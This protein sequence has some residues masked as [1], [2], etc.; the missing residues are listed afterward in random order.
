MALKYWARSASLGSK[1]PINSLTESKSIYTT[2]RNRLNGRTP[3]NIK[4][5]D[6]LEKHNLK[7]IEIQQQIFPAKFDLKSLNPKHELTTKIKKTE[8][9]MQECE[10]MAKTFF[11]NNYTR[12][13]QIY[14]DGSKDSAANTAGCAFTIPKLYK[15][16]TE[17]KI[18]PLL[19]VYEHQN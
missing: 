6:L 15:S 8:S 3:Y 12:H 2:C 18:T 13:L 14:T 10:K 16:H 7:E 1:L 19:T 5:Q 17:I 4:V 11:E 9:T